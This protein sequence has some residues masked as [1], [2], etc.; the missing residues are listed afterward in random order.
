MNCVAKNTY[1][2]VPLIAPS[3]LSV[4]R[5][6]ESAPFPPGNRHGASSTSFHEER[7]SWDL[8]KQGTKLVTGAGYPSPPMSGSPPFESARTAPGRSSSR[9][10]PFHGQLSDASHARWPVEQ[11][12]AIP[13]S[14]HGGLIPLSNTYPQETPRAPHFRRQSDHRLPPMLTY[15]TPESISSV[16]GTPRQPYVSPAP[17]I[18]LQHSE[19]QIRN[20]IPESNPQVTSPRSQRKTKG[21][22][23]SACVPCKRAHLRC[24][25][26]RPCSRCITHGKE[27]ACVDVQHKKRGRPRLRDDRDSRIE[28]ARFV[29][30]QDG[31]SRRQST[32]RP[33][34]MGRPLFYD[35]PGSTGPSAPPSEFTSPEIPGPGYR[36]RLVSAETH[37]GNDRQPQRPLEE[38]VL[39]MRTNMEVVK[40]ASAF[41]KAIGESV[42]IGRRLVDM[43]TPEAVEA[44]LEV[45]HILNSEQMRKEPTYLPPIFGSGDDAIRSLNFSPASIRRVDFKHRA[46]V[47]FRST[48]GQLRS[49]PMHFGL[50]KEGA[51]YFIAAILSIQ[52]RPM[53]QSPLPRTRH[54]SVVK[55]DQ[56]DGFGLPRASLVHSNTTAVDGAYRRFSGGNT[57]MRREIGMPAQPTPQRTSP[58]SAYQSI[59]SP[60]PHGSENARPLSSHQIPRSELGGPLLARPSESQYTL[61]PIRSLGERARESPG[62]DDK[63]R[64]VTI[65]GL[66]NRPG[67]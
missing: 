14:R 3:M 35:S 11:Q 41:S 46:Y 9:N 64:R 50:L 49:Y 53:Y 33:A 18:T 5:S 22:V 29:P 59:Y 7:F 57:A 47:T 8:L 32:I 66:I 56:G 31:V 26:Q 61:P 39:Y 40:A 6:V 27:D 55:G 52:S 2:K 28:A 36:P 63:Q 44:I 45:C 1:S 17:S 65:G 20:T 58:G 23:A 30:I 43:V 19:Q 51:F 21:H 24:D 67:N 42:P 4:H 13:A 48:D 15:N 37:L 12:A 54:A 60:S 16:H 62:R 38:P 10:S 34:S 25:A